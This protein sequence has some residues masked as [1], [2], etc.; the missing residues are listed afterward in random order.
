MGFLFSTVGSRCFRGM[1]GRV[2]PV[3]IDCFKLPFRFPHLARLSI[4]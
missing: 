2:V 1:I 3:A 4:E